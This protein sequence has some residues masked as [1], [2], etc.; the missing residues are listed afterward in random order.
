MH[1]ICRIDISRSEELP[2]KII[3]FVEKLTSRINIKKVYL[4]GSVAR[5]DLNEGSDIDL[6]IIGDFRERFIDRADRI[7]EMTELPIEPLCY[8]EKEF[9]EMKRKGNPFVKE[10]LKGKLLF[11]SKEERIFRSCGL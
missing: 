6:A 8:T 2:G 4:F 3:S 1:K 11:N 10:I 7:F 9:E 5:N